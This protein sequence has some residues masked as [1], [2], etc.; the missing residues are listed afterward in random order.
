MPHEIYKVGIQYN[1]QILVNENLMGVG[2]SEN[3]T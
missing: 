1:V 3:K 2:D